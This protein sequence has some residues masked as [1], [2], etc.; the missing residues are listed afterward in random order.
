MKAIRAG[1]CALVAFA[2]L[3]QGTTE[4]WSEAVVE[5]G[6]AL[7]LVWWCVIVLREEPIEIRGN[8]LLWPLLG[9]WIVAMVQS[10]PG[11]SA[12]AFATRIE[13]LKGSALLVLI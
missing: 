11:L 1:L 9:L 6:A 8:V 4:A 5:I 10:I 12:Y 3:A 13:W 7:L 2:V